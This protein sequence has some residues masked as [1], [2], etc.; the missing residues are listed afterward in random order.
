MYGFRNPRAPLIMYTIIKAL[1]HDSED[2]TFILVLVLHTNPT[3]SLSYWINMCKIAT[4]TMYNNMYPR[5]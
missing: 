5:M 4:A 1:L 2:S 3:H